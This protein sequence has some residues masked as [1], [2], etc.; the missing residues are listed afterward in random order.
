MP[1]L[2]RIAE[3]ETDM[4]AWRRHLHQHPETRFDCHQ[5]A[6]FIAARLRDFGIT[7]IHEGIAQSG[8]VAIIDGQGPGPTIGLRAD[9]DALPIGEETGLP[10]ASRV[11]GKMHACG[12][13]GHTTMLLGAARY[14]AET[15]NFAGRVALIFQPAEE[16]G[17]GAGVMV[18]EGIMERF[19]IS[20]VYALHNAPNLPLGRF[21]GRAGPLMAVKNAIE[22]DGMRAAHVR[23][24]AAVCRFLAWLAATAPGR[25]VSEIEA[26]QRLQ[27]FRA[28]GA[29]YRGPSFP[30]ISAAGPNAAIVHYK[31][32]AATNRTLAAGE[33]YLVDS[34]AQYRDGTTDVTR[35]LAIGTPAEEMCRRFTL[36]LKGHIA[37]ATVRFPKDTSGAQL[38]ALARR[39]LWDHGLDYDH[40]TGHGVGCYLNVHEGPQR[41]SKQPNRT[42]LQP[43]MIVSNE[44]GYYKAGAYGIRIE[45]LVLVVPLATP[46]DGEQPLFGF[47]TLTLAP[48]DRTLIAPALLEAGEIAWLDAYHARVRATLA[49]GLDAETRRWLEAAT[50]PLGS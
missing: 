43:G 11:P 17:G 48:I 1:V 33:L 22:Q 10:H 18:Q 38:D 46:A 23:D 31:P 32:S 25:P 3:Y 49:P 37:L 35:T 2:N 29:L 7:E 6:A 13:D 47:E 45:N 42:P 30:T 19:D 41:I 39:P 27:D 44:P 40:G 20:Q 4:T 36:V 12:H 26:A 50:R 8:I 28:A 15:R 21:E 24:G 16:W 14:L 5:T 9:I 34:G